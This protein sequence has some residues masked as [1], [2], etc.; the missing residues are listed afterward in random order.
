M[1]ER[2]TANC[3]KL[4]LVIH[5]D[6][7]VG[8]PGET[9][10]SIRKTIDFAKKLDNETIQVSIAHPY[11]GTEFYDYAVKN[12]LISIGNIVDERG[13]Q[14]PKVVY[15]NL[16]EAELMDWVERFYGEYY[17][18]TKVIWRMVRKVIFN[19]H[20]R[21]RL[22]KEAREYMALRARRRKFISDRR[23]QTAVS[24]NAGD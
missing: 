8:L 17:F 22:A 1:A 18:R 24:A 11:P 3:K 6:F 13:N 16:N 23:E 10:E 21:R 19:P 4:G 2:F 20:D 14:L 5:G 12:D 15:E 9:R 7:I